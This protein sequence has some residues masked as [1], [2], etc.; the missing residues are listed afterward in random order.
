MF[1]LDET[2][3]RE[4]KWP[5]QERSGVKSVDFSIVNV[6]VWNLDMRKFGIKKH[7]KMHFLKIKIHVTRNVGKVWIGRKRNLPAPFGVIFS[8]DRTNQTIANN[9]KF[10]LAGDLFP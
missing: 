8:M 1:R 9:R 2:L 3:G 7:L 5:T 10:S 6:D 4:L